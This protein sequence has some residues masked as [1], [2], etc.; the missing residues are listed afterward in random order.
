[1]AVH[2]SYR[3]KQSV[4]F[5]D[6][7]GGLTARRLLQMLQAETA[8]TGEQV[9][10]GLRRRDVECAG[11]FGACLDETRC[12][13]IAPFHRWRLFRGSTSSAAATSTRCSTVCI[14][15]APTDSCRFRRTRI[16]FVSENTVATGSLGEGG[17]MFSLE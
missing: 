5:I 9:S 10:G 17:I 11:L 8:N 2:V 14:V 7:S 6:T 3:L 4:I 12:D 1:M 13:V 15:S 16:T